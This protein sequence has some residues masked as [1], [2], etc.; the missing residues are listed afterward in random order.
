MIRP[1]VFSV[2]GAV[3]AAV[4]CCGAVLAAEPTLTTKEA[5][6]LPA[7]VKQNDAVTFKLVF[8]DAEGD[9]IRSSVMRLKTPSGAESVING[10]NVSND[11]TNG[12]DVTFEAKMNEPG[13]YTPTFIVSSVDGDVTY[14]AQGQAPYQFSVENLPI[15]IGVFVVGLLV[16]LAFLPMLV[17]QL[18]RSL[19]RGGDPSGAARGGLLVGILMCGALFMSLFASFLGVYAYGIGAIG[20]LTGIVMVL[21]QKRR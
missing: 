21:T 12:V 10:K 20:A 5:E 16:G 15:K 14:P 13:Q 18:F 19:N 11:T 17:Y 8:K 7:T 3:L 1:R 9:R 6:P 2:L 4:I